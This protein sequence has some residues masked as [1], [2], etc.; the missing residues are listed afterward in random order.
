MPVC[1]FAATPEK[2][3][4]TA[5]VEKIG[6]IPLDDIQI[7]GIWA[8][9]RS[10]TVLLVDS[11]G[12]NLLRLGFEPDA[13]GSRL[14]SASIEAGGKDMKVVAMLDG[15]ERTL[16][17]PI[18]KMPVPEQDAVKAAMRMALAETNNKGAPITTGG[19]GSS[20]GNPSAK[21]KPGSESPVA[22]TS[23]PGMG[24]TEEDRKKY[25]SLSDEAKEKFR[26]GM[27]EMF[28]DEQFRNAPEE[29]RRNA[30]RDLFDKIQKDDSKP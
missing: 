25:E 20:A 9:D 26:N 3:D 17:R 21:K 4:K 24:P 18:A 28:S 14:I 16:I 15:K 11:S 13:N 1:F 12:K 2:E 27:R 30:I 8:V 23:K 7:Y 29:E 5:T 22:S 6:G 10:A 19:F